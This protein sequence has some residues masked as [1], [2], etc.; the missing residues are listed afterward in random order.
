MR[1]G[2][3]NQRSLG[4][5]TPKRERRKSEMIQAVAREI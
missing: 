2:G 3:L 5:G 1:M 4:K